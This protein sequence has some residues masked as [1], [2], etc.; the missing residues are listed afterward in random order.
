M[1]LLEAVR[2]A[3]TGDEKAQSVL[4]EVM[5]KRVYYLIL[6]LVKNSQDAED[7]TQETFLSA[8]G[9]LP[10]L[11]NDNAFEGWIFQIAANKCRNKL[12]RTKQTEELPEDFEE[13]TPDLH[14]NLLPESVLQSA[15]KR[16]ILLEFIESLPDAQQECVML[17]Y[18]SEMSVKQIAESLGCSEG[19][20]KSRLNYARQKIKE[21]VLEMEERDD[22]RLHVFIPLGLV[23]AKDFEAIT[24]GLTAAA[25]GGTG[26]AVSAA[27]AGGTAGSA[28]T[29]ILATLKAK[30]VAGVTAVTVVGGAVAVSQLPAPIVFSDPAMEQNIRI[31]ADKPEGKLYPSDVEEIHS[32]YIL[33]NGMDIDDWE[34]G[35]T[36]DKPR[37]GT[38][39]PDS[40]SDLK[41][42][43]N[44]TF[45]Y[46]DAQNLS[47][48]NTL[49]ENKNLISL[50]LLGRSRRQIAV[51]DLH[52][53]DSLPKLKSFQAMVAEDADLSPIEQHRGI[54][55]LF[56]E[57]QGS[58]RLKAD[59]L[60]QLLSLSL[61]ANAGGRT[62]GAAGELVLTKEL[63]E[64][65]VLWMNGGT[66]PSLQFLKQMPKLEFLNIYA[67]NMEQLDL[68]PL[69][70]LKSLRAIHLMGRNRGTLDLAPL[71]ACSRLEVY[72]VL[73]ENI[74]NPPVQAMKETDSDNPHFNQIA[75]EVQE[76]VHNLMYGEEWG[77]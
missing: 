20:V 49:G 64:L 10:N 59:D 8:F 38:I 66:V 14:E 35:H 47:L 53:L 1:E 4:Y 28:K 62:P 70:S 7:V 32:V 46:Y 44:L 3:K 13:H 26:A 74:I 39:A 27:A 33:D 56:L 6:R 58:L 9:A 19:T 57:S 71:S 52:F 54:Q 67:E 61:F 60:P 41:K 51:K 43:P 73:N 2:E 75:F 11:K 48:L 34:N 65:R 50:N 31:L 5:Y 36:G 25:F 22:I 23:L 68:R 40:L 76:E 63:P 45:I 72:N 69:G 16:R 29:G 30:V 42:L 24:A 18:Y 55:E 15:E 77:E 17:F 21:Q 37:A 12:S